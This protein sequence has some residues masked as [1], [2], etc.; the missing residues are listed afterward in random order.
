M[1]LNLFYLNSSHPWEIGFENEGDFLKKS[2]IYRA[3]SFFF[4]KECKMKLST[5]YM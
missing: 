5:G 3:S 4:S 1:A 2:V